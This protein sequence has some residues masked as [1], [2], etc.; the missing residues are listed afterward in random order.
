VCVCVGVCVR[1]CALSQCRRLREFTG[2][3]FT[4]PSLTRGVSLSLVIAGG[5]F[6]FEANTKPMTAQEEPRGPQRHSK[7]DVSY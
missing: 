4:G 3:E 6:S 2:Q 7:P 5:V 1:V